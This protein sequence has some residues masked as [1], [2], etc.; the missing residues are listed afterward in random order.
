[1]FCKKN[2]L[3]SITCLL[4]TTY[5]STLGVDLAWASA[6]DLSYPP[7]LAQ[8][9]TNQTYEKEIK[10]RIQ[11]VK[12]NKAQLLEDE[13]SNMEGKQ[14]I[15]FNVMV[16][17]ALVGAGLLLGSNEIEQTINDI[18]L[19]P[20]NTRGEQDKENAL[21]AL[22][23]VEQVGWGV[24][25]VGVL[26]TIWYFTYSVITDQKQ[27]EQNKLLEESDNDELPAVAA[28]NKEI[29]RLK[30][31]QNRRTFAQHAFS[32]VAIGSL[33]TGGLLWGI[34]GP[35]RDNIEDIEIDNNDIV[36]QQYR[37]EALEVTDDMEKWGK[38]LVIAGAVSGVAAFIAW[39]LADNKEEVDELEKG[40]LRANHHIDINPQ[41]DGFVFL[42]SYNF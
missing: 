26:S 22:Q 42:Y 12:K 1:M 29:N 32:S 18:E 37:C 7:L 28:V 30:E 8:I 5:C 40:L 39:W 9:F 21:N 6:Q 2:I 24:A 33:I 38:G 3:K 36:E 13:I 20:E 11:K 27:E 19:E 25:G 14:E 16:S 41:P 17:S 31:V 10:E 35:L 34:S 23:S 4:I 15:L